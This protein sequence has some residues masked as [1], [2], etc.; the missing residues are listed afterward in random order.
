MEESKKQTIRLTEMLKVGWQMPQI[1]LMRACHTYSLLA[2]YAKG[3]IFSYK[4]RYD[5]YYA[6]YQRA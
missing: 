3:E 5:L 1:L 6:L 4:I 2:P